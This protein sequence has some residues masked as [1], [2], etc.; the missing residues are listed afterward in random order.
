ME[1]LE[2]TTDGLFTRFYPQTRAGEVAW[3]EMAQFD[4]TAAVLNFEA[5]R[6]IS[7]LRRAGY[8]VAKAKAR[9]AES[10]DEILKE[11]EA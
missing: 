3:K 6:V 11:L 5:R 9:G 8:S 1:D 7:D 4:G 10:I 2:Y